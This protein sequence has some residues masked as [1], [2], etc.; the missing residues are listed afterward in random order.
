MTT[1]PTV[2]KQQHLEVQCHMD[3]LPDRDNNSDEWEVIDSS[4]DETHN[5]GRMSASLRFAIMILCCHVILGWARW[6]LAY[7]G[8]R[9]TCFPTFRTYQTKELYQEIRIC[10]EQLAR[11]II[12]NWN[13]RPRS[14]KHHSQQDIVVP[15]ISRDEHGMEKPPFPGAV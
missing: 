1:T 4:R 6:E 12:P 5:P 11:K 14:R 2:R 15:P 10:S 9:H 7:V 8:N 13:K 3:D